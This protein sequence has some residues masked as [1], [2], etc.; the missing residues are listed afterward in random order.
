MAKTHKAPTKSTAK[1]P[2]PPPL[3]DPG[4]VN[5]IFATEVVGAGMIGGCISVNLAAHRWNVTASGGETE[6]SRALVARL[7]LSR[8]AATQLMNG[9]ANLAQAAGNA[10]TAN[11]DETKAKG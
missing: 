4:N 6:I 11:P 2:T 10:A 7:M 5:E 8:E 1:T 9:L 3:D